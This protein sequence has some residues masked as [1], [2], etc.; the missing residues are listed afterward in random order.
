MKRLQ[1]ALAICIPLCWFFFKLLPVYTHPASCSTANFMYAENLVATNVWSYDS[2]PTNSFDDSSNVLYVVCLWI[3]IHFF[4]FTTVKAALFISAFSILFSVY[5]LQR[6]IDSRFYGINLLLVGLLFMS[7]QIWAGVLGDEILFQGMLWLF[8]IRSFWKHRYFWLMIWCTVNIIARPDNAFILLSLIIVSYFDIRELKDRYKNRFI[9][10]RVG[11]TIVLLILPLCFYFIYRYLY[12]GKALPYNWLHQLQTTDTIK[13][14]FS[15]EA[16]YF[17]VH[18]SRFYILPLC[19]G[20]F[21]YFLKERKSL[22][23]RYYALAI[24]F[25]VIPI[26]YNCTFSQTENLAYKNYY[27]IYLG[28]ILLSLLFIRDFRSISQSVTTAIFVLFFGF[29]LSFAYFGKTLQSYNN[30]QYYIANDLA[31]IHNGKLVAYNDNF[32]SWMGNWQTTFANGKHS[33]EY[34]LLNTDS[35]LNLKSD[36]ILVASIQNIDNYQSK[37]VAFSVPQNTLMYQKAINPEN[38]IDKF[39]YK[40][41]YK[42]PLNKNLSNT[43]LVLKSSKKFKTIQKILLQY[44]AKEIINDRK[45]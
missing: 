30:N 17:L 2:T 4:K 40:Y 35:I 45:K 32:I 7:T 37:Y 18:Y 11:N 15:K 12:F 27:A 19:I 43:Y 1:F 5:L 3:L 25:I 21:F 24:A 41:T 26:F 13:G 14:I 10:R 29:K 23:I 31:Q 44:G 22:H 39:F 8:A 9:R 28:L 38:S 42:Y 20:V 36:I 16:F 33:K 6:I 34:K